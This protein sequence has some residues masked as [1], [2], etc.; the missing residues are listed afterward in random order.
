MAW[1]YIN[2]PK[3]MM[4]DSK[5]INYNYFLSSIRKKHVSVIFEFLKRQIGRDP[6][7]DVYIVY[8]R[9]YQRSIPNTSFKF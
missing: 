9:V 1:H 7:D 4:S 2:Q 5:L 8:F 3:L 6:D